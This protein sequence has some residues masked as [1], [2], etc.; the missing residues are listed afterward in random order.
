MSY[1]GAQGLDARHRSSFRENVTRFSCVLF[2][3][4]KR[5]G[6]AKK[7]T[8]QHDAARGLRSSARVLRKI[9]VLKHTYAHVI[10]YYISVQSQAKELGVVQ[11]AVAIANASMPPAG[12]R[13]PRLTEL[14]RSRK[15]RLIEIQDLFRVAGAI[16]TE[17]AGQGSHLVIMHR[18]QGYVC[19][20]LCACEA[21]RVP[22]EVQI[23]RHRIPLCPSRWRCTRSG[24]I[25][26]AAAIMLKAPGTAPHAGEGV[27]MSSCTLSGMLNQPRL[28]ARNGRRCQH[29]W[30]TPACHRRARCKAL[31][32]AMRGQAQQ[33]A[34]AA[35]SRARAAR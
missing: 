29:V 30:Q 24:S 17:I 3:T 5:A 6:C 32:G 33:Q 27:I 8:K 31:K 2:Q 23:A 18:C 26:Q 19:P 15:A 28:T 9:F 11:F 21:R 20:L 1:V 34:R 4:T 7:C 12:S 35:A 14:M 22:P 13:K 25:L 16:R 10:A